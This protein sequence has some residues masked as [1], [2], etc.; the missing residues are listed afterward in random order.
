VAFT[1]GHDRTLADLA[2]TTAQ[3]GDQARA[4]VLLRAAMVAEASVV[5]A[6]NLAIVYA[7]VGRC[8][9]AVTALQEASR[10]LASTRRV[11]ARERAV[12]D[13]A[14]AAVRACEDPE[15]PPTLSGGT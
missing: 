1:G 14:T 9:D 10:R 4:A 3:R 13:A 11:S 6:A 5:P 12:A 15:R 8:D 7:N 2:W